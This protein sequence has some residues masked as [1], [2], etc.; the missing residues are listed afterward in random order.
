M[1]QYTKEGLLSDGQIRK[2]VEGKYINV[3]VY[4]TQIGFQLETI[5]DPNQD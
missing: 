3:K 4:T 2:F 5:C 1:R